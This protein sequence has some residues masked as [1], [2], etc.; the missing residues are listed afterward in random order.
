METQVIHKYPEQTGSL[1]LNKLEFRLNNSRGPRFTLTLDITIEL[2][3][4]DYKN[5]ILAYP[6]PIGLKKPYS[7]YNVVASNRVTGDNLRSR[8]E[9]VENMVS[10]FGPGI[11]KPDAGR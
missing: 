8:E 9:P 5:P 10:A 7:P 2:P 6:F 4:E 1:V 11:R 3:S